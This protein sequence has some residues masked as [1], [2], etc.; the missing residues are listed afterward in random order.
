MA[1][2]PKYP[3]YREPYVWLVIFFPSVA[4]IGGLITLKIALF[5]R[6]SLVVD[7]YYKQGLEINR[8]FERDRAANRYGLQAT[9]QFKEDRI[10]VYLTSHPHYSK[11]KQIMLHFIHHTRADA[12]KNL[13][14]ERSSDDLYQVQLPQLMIGK[15]DIELFAENWRLM[16]TFKLPQDFDQSLFIHPLLK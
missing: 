7:D 10:L 6:D 9:L 14:L 2:P 3:W 13:I 8:T 12:D 11:P 15:W 16:G 5:S 1:P 4:V